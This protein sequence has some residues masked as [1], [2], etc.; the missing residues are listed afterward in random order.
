MVENLI[1]SKVEKE[2]KNFEI[3]L[4]AQQRSVGDMVEYKV[5]NI[6]LTLKTHDYIKNCFEPKSKKSTEDVKIIDRDGISI[7]VD[8]KT[9][10]INSKFS[11]PNLISIDKLRTIIPNEKVSLIYIFVDYEIVDSIVSFT[12]IKVKK[13][14]ELDMSILR[15]GSLGKGQLQIANMNKD[16]LFTSEGRYEWFNKLKILVKKYHNDRINKIEKEKLKWV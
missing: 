3:N 2:L 15:I 7:F 16:L 1:L 6:L 8:T 14:W 4:G 5:K 11:M 10:D 9:H 12:S 13:V